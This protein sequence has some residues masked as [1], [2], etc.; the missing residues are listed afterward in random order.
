MTQERECCD[1][2]RFYHTI[3]KACRRYPAHPMMIGVKQNVL[4]PNQGEPQIVSV[5]PS[6]EKHGWCGEYRPRV[7]NM[8]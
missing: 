2:C 8:Q 1:N 4:N 5:F 7:E 6:M 3:S